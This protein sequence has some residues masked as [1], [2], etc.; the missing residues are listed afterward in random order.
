MI[1]VEDIGATWHIGSGHSLSGNHKSENKVEYTDKYYNTA[2]SL[3]GSLVSESNY[4]TSPVQ[5]S[6]HET[7]CVKGIL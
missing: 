2:F 1:E 6:N 4:K 5:V 7:E 3:T